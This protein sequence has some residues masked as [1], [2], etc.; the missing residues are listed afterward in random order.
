[1][2]QVEPDW[3]EQYHCADDLTVASVGDATQK[4]SQPWQE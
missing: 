1:M 4:G 3:V 2:D